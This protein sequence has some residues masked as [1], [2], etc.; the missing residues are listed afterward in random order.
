MSDRT[1]IRQLLKKLTD[2]VATEEESRLLRQLI[3]EDEQGSLAEEANIY[4]SGQADISTAEGTPDPYW[5]QAVRNIL[6]VDKVQP[7][8]SFRLYWLAAASVLLLAVVA[9]IYNRETRPAPETAAQATTADIAPGK[10]GAVLTLSDG[11]KVTLD[12]L[13]NGV[14]AYQQGTQV[15]IRNGQLAYDPAGASTAAIA[16][17]TMTTP[18]G[19]QFRLQLPDGTS[20]WLN[21]ASSI[22][23]P[24]AFTG[25]ERNVRISGEVY[26]E[27]AHN[28]AQPFIVNVDDHAYIKV[29]GTHFNVQAYR[30][31]ASIHTTL[32]EG[33]IV[34]AGITLQPGQQARLSRISGSAPQLADQVDTDKVMAWKN[35]LFNF[36]GASLEEVMKQLERWYDIEVIY[37]KGIPDITFGGKMTKGVSLKGVLT[38]LEKSEVHFKLE[39]R[40]LIVLP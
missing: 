17:N 40:K 37:E 12:S 11:T 1:V 4:F 7:R 39:G 27:V 13:G 15:I 26:F 2:G 38:A 28:A 9:G 32:L 29:L 18:K 31:D 34:T 24:T 30:D 33:S 16:Y 10:E 14:V 25:K 19:R 23:F 35:G 36:N 20:A 22:R 5:E 3:T 8:R 21:A 6:D